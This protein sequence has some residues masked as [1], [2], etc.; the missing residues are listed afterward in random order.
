MKFNII[1]FVL[2][3]ILLL[4]VG[5]HIYLGFNT[6]LGATYDDQRKKTI[7]NLAL[8]LEDYANRHQGQYPGNIAGNVN[9]M[10]HTWSESLLREGFIKQ[11]P[12]KIPFE[13]YSF[14]YC[15]SDF[16]NNKVNNFCYN[17][18]GPPS[19]AI[20]WTNLESKRER[21]KCPK[22]LYGDNPEAYYVW[23]SK[24]DKIGIVCLP[25][26]GAS[27]KGNTFQNYY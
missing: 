4:L 21:S 1:D 2:T 14:E 10:F 25:V 11:I 19:D 18:F 13:D 8:A 15:G 26:R 24:D 7:A 3:I 17:S 5:A 6:T 27:L 23:S 12:Q 9:P 16:Y 20:V 22:G